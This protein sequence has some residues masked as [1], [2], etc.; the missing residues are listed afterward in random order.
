M[1]LNSQDFREELRV[2]Q[3]ADHLAAEAVVDGMALQEA[4]REAPQP[5]QIIAQRALARAA[6]VLAEVHVQH[7]V[8]RLDAPMTADRLAESLT[9]E[10]AAEDVVPRLV[11]L[12]A[13]GVLGHPQGIADGFDPRPLL[14]QGEV[15][16]DPGEEIRPLVDP[17]VRSFAGLKAAVP[18]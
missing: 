15:G 12:T 3:A 10:I 18:E 2:H 5:A 13:V 9:A 14:L 6:V 16:W 4:H 8:H 17:A 11:R 7:P 1:S